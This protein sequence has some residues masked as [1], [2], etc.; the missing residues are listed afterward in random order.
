MREGADTRLADVTIERLNSEGFV[1]ARALVT[2]GADAGYEIEI[3][4][5]IDEFVRCAKNL[6]VGAIFVQA[7]T[8]DEED[9][10]SDFDSGGGAGTDLR[11]AERRLRRFEERIGSCWMVETVGFFGNNSLIYRQVE[12]WFEEFARIREETISLLDDAEEVE[13]D[14]VRR[15]SDTRRR[16][17]IEAIR[18][19]ARDVEFHEYI[20]RRPT[21]RAVMAY[22][23][24]TIPDSSLLMRGVMRDE[25]VKLCDKLVVAG[26]K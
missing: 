9:F 26:G 18:A 23:R 12:D 7:M 1:V 22:I 25:V 24:E 8:L 11:T 2:K 21:Q 20:G 14:E 4:K 17:A 13:R 15:E 6:S 5:S 3:E 10:F 16:S 19:L